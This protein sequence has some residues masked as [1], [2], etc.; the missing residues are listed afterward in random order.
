MLYTK[1]ATSAKVF[2]LVSFFVFFFISV[3]HA[4]VFDISSDKQVLHPKLESVLADL[5][6]EHQK[7]AFSAQTFA[8]QRD[9]AIEDHEKITVFIIFK[10]KESVDADALRTMGAEIIKG[11]DNVIK[12]S[13]PIS[14]LVG[15][16][17]RIKGIAFIQLPSRPHLDTVS[18]GVGITNASLHHSAGVLGTGV[19][20][21][22]IDAGFSGLTSAISAGELPN[23]VINVDCTGFGCVG[24]N[25]PG[26]T[27]RHGTAVAEIVY[28]MAPGA[29]LYLIKI[30]DFLD[31]VDAK[32]Y[33][34][35]NGIKIVNF[36]AGWVGTNFFDGSCY[37]S[38]PV[39][40]TEDAY[41][42]GILWVN[43]AGN[44]AQRHYEATFSDT[45][46][47]SFYNIS[48]QNEF[49]I[50]EAQAG[51]N[52]EVYLNWNAWPTT[53]QDYDLFLVDDSPVQ[54]VL[55]VSRTVQN[56]AQP[57]VE[58]ISYKA[59]YTGVYRVAVRKF[60]AST[61][62]QFEIYSLK[63]ELYPSI[64]SSSLT[65]PAD[66]E[67]VMAVGAIPYSDWN[68]GPQA[69][70]SSQGPTNDGWPKP[71]I[72]GPA[73]VSSYAYGDHFHGTSAAAPHVAGAA[74]LIL[75]ANPGFLVSQLWNSLT[76]SAIDMGAS[77]F[78]NIYGYGRLNLQPQ[79]MG[80]IG[81]AFT[82]TGSGLGTKKPK[83]YVEYEKKP[84]IYGKAYARVTGWSDSFVSCLWTVKLSPGT[85]NLFVQPALKG[86][87]P[88][89]AGTFSIMNPGIETINPKSCSIGEQNTVSGKFFSSKKPKV[90]LQNTS[91]L[92]KYSCKVSSF[93]M[94]PD[95]GDSVLQFS[96]PKVT[97]LGLTEY[98]LI[99][100]NTIGQ[101]TT[102]FCGPIN[103]L[104]FRPNDW[105]DNIVVSK[106]TGSA[107]DSSPIY[108][109]DTLYLDWAVI[110]N[111]SAATSAVFY[112]DL[113]L[114]G[115]KKASWPFN[116]PL[117][118]NYY[119]YIKDYSLGSLSAGTHNLR[120]VAD[121]A[122]AIN[123]SNEDDNEYTKTINV[124]N[125][126]PPATSVQPGVW[127]GNT[128]A[129]NVS[130]D[131]TRLTSSGS[132]LWIGNYQLPLIVI[133]GLSGG[134]CDGA[135]HRVGPLGD[136]T[137]N[138]KS[139]G[140]NRTGLALN[141]QFT[142]SSNSNGTLVLTNYNIPDCG[143]FNGSLSWTASPGYPG[144]LSSSNSNSSLNETD[145]YAIWEVNT[146]YADIMESADESDW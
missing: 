91:T 52:I 46:A 10:D 80:T 68:S 11:T 43:A 3:S 47:N 100:Q 12:V 23:T 63:H 34:I 28:D 39:C 81:T 115:I 83:V 77:G 78:D 90:Y 22:V 25:F 87:S 75:S 111:G 67:H 33:C 94:N 135:T 57:P 139:F 141:G 15:M 16:A 29:Q 38:N 79:L 73:A 1:H 31:L 146:D 37:N 69:M 2:L 17:E 74:A 99:L 56:G 113:Y 61:N 86:V 45:N 140:W 70:Y 88:I 112:T 62:H 30:V 130:S 36:S 93:S 134:P 60:S 122:Y 18:E 20:V 106:V 64:A 107:T 117:D 9:L 84:G 19:K 4:Q 132:S 42:S 59:L 116:P 13:A 54:N 137:I 129:F 138:N 44:Q 49:F 121:S 27:E 50:I 85:Y 110:N 82:L 105:A 89:P 95:T 114:D 97:D 120:I 71:E 8:K 48:P 26:E 101:T 72:M 14:N 32:N 133:F 76:N 125:P 51:Q 143:S 55:A 40:T 53:N 126:P 142:S 136:I 58:I 5:Y 65:S 24:T 41:N 145:N 92:K 103:L 109:T 98:I 7:G 118:P 104:P 119:A 66:A 102:D 131:G 128:V 21:A 124:I 35:A 96:V 123:E 108:T 6:K 127:S 144:W